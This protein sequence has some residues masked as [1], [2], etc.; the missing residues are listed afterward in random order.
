MDY[1][2]T[3][4]LIAQARRE[5]GMTQRDLANRL[6]ITDRAVSKWE[7]GVSF[8]DVATLEPLSEVLE[9]P[10]SQLITGT[11]DV[12][13]TEEAL[14]EG[15]QTFKKELKT[16]IRRAAW[17]T[18]VI[19]A[20]V[21]ALTIGICALWR[22]V[23]AQ[24]T[25]IREMH[26]STK[27]MQIAGTNGL[28]AAKFHIQMAPD[29][30][31]CYLLEETWAPYGMVSSEP[32]WATG[33]HL[34]AAIIQ[35]YNPPASSWIRTRKTD[36]TIGFSLNNTE[37]T[38]TWNCLMA[39]GPLHQYSG[40]YPDDIYVAWC[41]SYC[42]LT[43]TK[44]TKDGAVPLMAVYLAKNTVPARFGLEGLKPGA[45]V[46]VMDGGMVKVLWLVVK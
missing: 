4:Q 15:V 19:M 38:Y 16:K 26:L 5:R 25:A 42:D 44:L 9:L 13:A 45:P 31:M 20:G 14:Q 23:P 1:A 35:Q 33:E 27:E 29:V 46:P 22:Y 6:H 3:G 32:I 41:Q 18:V 21:A 28:S 43:K 10:L 2:K 37:H 36:V 8:P 24:R 40:T 34:S 11:H 7:R 12:I 30:Q 39:E 17:L